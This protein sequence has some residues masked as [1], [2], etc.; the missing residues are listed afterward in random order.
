MMR[1]P[2]PQDVKAL[3]DSVRKGSAAYVGDETDFYALCLSANSSRAVVRDW[4]DTTVG[5]AKRNTARWFDLQS[6][7]DPRDG[8]PSGMNPEPLSLFRLAVSTVRDPGDLPPATPRRLFR[9]AL[10]GALLPMEIAFQAVRRNRAERAVRKERAALIKLVLLSRQPQPRK[11]KH[12]VALDTEHPEVAYHCGRLL[13][14]IEQAQYAALGKV[15]ASVVDR[16]YGSASATPGVV[17]GTLLRGVQPHLS[18]LQGARRGGIQNRLME[19]C[20]RI[21]SFPKTLNLEQQ[22]L[23]SLGYY[24]QQAHGRAEA[25]K[26][27]ASA[28]EQLA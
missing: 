19:V 22:A 9:F 12:M 20:D 8:D 3:L 15:G 18:K 16:Y 27:R 6:I 2:N 24:H 7:I 26:R 4:I 10:S 5:A 17:F 23:F 14:V 21:G 25:R 13:A 28:G 11:E 1:D